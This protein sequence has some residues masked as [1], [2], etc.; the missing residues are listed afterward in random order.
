MLKPI[1]ADVLLRIESTNSESSRVSEDAKGDQSKQAKKTDLIE[2]TSN[3]EIMKNGEPTATR[4]DQVDS[5]DEG[6]YAHSKH[7]SSKN[8][9]IFLF[10]CS[11]F[12][13][14]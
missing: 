11:I 7:Y 6:N 8:K 9:L 2:T 1:H 13:I 10:S 4:C 3:V 12:S 14:L 5:N